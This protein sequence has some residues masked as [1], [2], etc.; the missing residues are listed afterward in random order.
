MLPDDPRHADATFARAPLADDFEAAGEVSDMFDEYETYHPSML[1]FMDAGCN[2]AAGQG[3]CESGRWS[4]T[5]ARQARQVA[6][7]R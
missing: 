1:G 7:D 4:K 5:L 2:R 6:T 3:V